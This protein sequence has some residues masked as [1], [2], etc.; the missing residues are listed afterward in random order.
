MKVLFVNEPGVN[1]L[2]TM[3]ECIPLMRDAFISLANGGVVPPGVLL[4]P[5]IEAEVAFILGRD[6]DDDSD[7]REAYLESRRRSA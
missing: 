1:E 2:L 4:Q 3:R 5:K 6:L 7:V